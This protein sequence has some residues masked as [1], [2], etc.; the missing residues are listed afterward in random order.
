MLALLV[1]GAGIGFLASAQ[2]WW[3]A[4]GDQAAVA[5]TGSDATGGLS[6]AL[7]AV[8]LAGALLV[9][10]LRPL[11]RRVLAVA[12]AAT[13]IG[14]VITGALLTAP[15]ADTVRG[16]VRQLSLTD[17]F[18]VVATAWPWVYAVAGLLVLISAVLL[19]RGGA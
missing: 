12:L 19:W 15:D 4:S 8:T 11:G 16:R 7:A 13:G 10:V 9:L 14:M 6:Q 3:Q 2:A 17:Q 5:F 1:L 18:A